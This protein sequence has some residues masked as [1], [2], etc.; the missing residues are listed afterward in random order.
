MRAACRDNFFFVQQSINQKTATQR[1]LFA[2]CKQSQQN[3]SKALQFWQE[4]KT[5]NDLLTALNFS[6]SINFAH[7]KFPLNYQLLTFKSSKFTFRRSALS[8]AHSNHI[9]NHATTQ[10]FFALDIRD[11]YV[12]NFLLIKKHQFIT[13]TTSYNDR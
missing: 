8:F 10:L 5:I 11:S 2:I 7:W 6:I 13:S 4:L 1:T 12:P 9:N 3:T